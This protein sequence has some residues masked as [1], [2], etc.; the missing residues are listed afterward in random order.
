M[1]ILEKDSYR[2][3]H[4]DSPKF[5]LAP[6]CAPH[7]PVT[8]HID[9]NAIRI[10]LEVGIDLVHHRAEVRRRARM[11]PG[12]ATAAATA[13]LASTTVCTLLVLALVASACGRAYRFIAVCGRLDSVGR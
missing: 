9:K 12:V 5:T 3:K 11:T 4:H 10:S 8:T 7:I 13:S 2:K 6:P 1:T